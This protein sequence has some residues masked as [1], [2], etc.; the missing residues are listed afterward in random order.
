MVQ[1]PPPIPLAMAIDQEKATPYPIDDLPPS[2]SN[3]TSHDS[4]FRHALNLLTRV[5][6]RGI[7]R[8]TPSEST[9]TLSWR[10]YL[11]T[12]VLWVSINLAA[13]NITLGMLAPTVFGLGFTDAAVCAVVGSAIGSA[14]VA[15]VGTWGP[16]SGCRTMVRVSGV[17]LRNGVAREDSLRKLTFPAEKNHEL[18]I[19]SADSC[20]DLRKIYHGVVAREI[21]C[22]TKPHRPVRVCSHRLRCRRADLV[23][24]LA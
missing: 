5:E 1:S 24:S 23:C 18:Q 9:V 22:T 6:S 20:I 16:R 4:T 12:F 15:Y 13:V 21:S 2:N 8:V 14:C 10:S 3:R 17:S 19:Q 11:Q 7:Q